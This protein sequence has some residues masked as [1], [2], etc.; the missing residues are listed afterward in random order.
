MLLLKAYRSFYGAMQ[1]YLGFQDLA[2]GVNAPA[3]VCAR[4]RQAQREQ[5]IG[6]DVDPKFPCELIL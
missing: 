2:K 6:A 5:D 1:M 3:S 4:V